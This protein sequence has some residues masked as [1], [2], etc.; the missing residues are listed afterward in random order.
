MPVLMFRI[1]SNSEIIKIQKNIHAQSCVFRRAVITRVAGTA[2]AAAAEQ[3]QGG[4]SFTCDWL[5]AFQVMSNLNRNLILVP[6]DE[7]QYH[8]DIR[9]DLTL[10]GED[11]SSD[12]L[13]NVYNYVGDDTLVFATGG[14]VA[15]EFAI[16]YIDLF[17]EF[18]ELFDYTTT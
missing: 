12:F 4:I 13:V 8:H 6:I 3:V 7:T 5:K 10:D 18:D 9:F 16:K 2:P 1:K 11:I 15:T 17:F 14:Q